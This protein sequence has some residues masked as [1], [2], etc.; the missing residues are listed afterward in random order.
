MAAS[1][2]CFSLYKIKFLTHLNLINCVFEVD[3][4]IEGAKFLELA[5]LLRKMRGIKM[6]S[7]NIFEDDFLFVVQVV[8]T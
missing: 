8:I 7:A 5:F 1:V 2:C 6:F 4:V 3:N